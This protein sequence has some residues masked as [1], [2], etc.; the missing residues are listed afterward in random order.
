MHLCEPDSIAN[1]FEEPCWMEIIRL[2]L[3]HHYPGSEI[4]LLIARFFF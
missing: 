4:P 3:S 1:K 2:M